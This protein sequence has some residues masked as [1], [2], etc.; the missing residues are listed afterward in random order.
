MP[1]K[2]YSVHLLRFNDRTNSRYTFSR[3]IVLESLIRESENK[4]MAYK[5]RERL[6][7][8]QAQEPVPISPPS[9][10]QRIRQQRF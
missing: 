6:K 2:A 5:S 1:C 8:L 7:I 10:V 3:L 9:I 4:E